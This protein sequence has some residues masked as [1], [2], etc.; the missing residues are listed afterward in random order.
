MPPQKVQEPGGDFG[1]RAVIEGQ[2]HGPAVRFSPTD[3]GQEEAD[4]GK[5][6]GNQA[7]K[8]ENPQRNG[9][10]LRSDEQHEAGSEKGRRRGEKGR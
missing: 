3:H 4:P 5:E 2:R 8:D 10:Q 7:K 6:R 1:I 9:N